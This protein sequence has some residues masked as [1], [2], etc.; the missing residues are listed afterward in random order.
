MP[1]GFLLIASQAEQAAITTSMIVNIAITIAIGIISFFLKRTISNLDDKA[2]K[3]ELESAHRSNRTEIEKIQ[4]EIVNR[5]TKD[6]LNELKKDVGDL[7]KDVKSITE[8]Y[9][10]KQDFVREMTRMENNIISNQDRV[11]ELLIKTQGG[12]SGR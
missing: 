9:I 6:E 1:F 4:R 7:K 3:S 12:N 8:N 10:T 5:V 2:T 11:V